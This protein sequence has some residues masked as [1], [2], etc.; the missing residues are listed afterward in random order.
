[1]HPAQG[2]ATHWRLVLRARLPRWRRARGSP[3]GRQ[4]RRLRGRADR[5]GDVLDIALEHVEAG[6]QPV[7]V[8][9]ERADRLAEPALF[10]LLVE[11]AVRDLR[12]GALA[13]R[14]GSAGAG[15]S[16]VAMRRKPVSV[17]AVRTAVRTATVASPTQT[18]SRA[19]CMRRTAVIRA[20]SG[21]ESNREKR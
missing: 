5:A 3:D 13:L 20:D 1:V 12:C 18:P 16:S 6:G 8:G 15:E 10:R 17:R 14:T 9:G 11:R 2:F 4:L 21:N 19:S 7:A